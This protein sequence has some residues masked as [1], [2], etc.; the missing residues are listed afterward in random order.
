MKTIPAKIKEKYPKISKET[1]M[2][3]E[4]AAIAVMGFLAQSKPQVM[5]SAKKYNEKIKDP[6]REG[7]QEGYKYE[8]I[9]EKNWTKF[10]HYVYMGSAREL[11]QGTASPEMNQYY[12][13]IQH[14]NQALKINQLEK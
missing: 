13:K 6:K 10:V 7:I 3:P 9:T 4:H 1:L 14:W 5:T 2:N 11:T 8:P 12:K